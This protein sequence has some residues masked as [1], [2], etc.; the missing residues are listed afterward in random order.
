MVRRKYVA[1]FML[2]LLS[3]LVASTVL[4]RFLIVV[5]PET[6][7]LDE[8]LFP[9]L[10]PGNDT[11]GTLPSPSVPVKPRFTMIVAGAAHTHYL[12]R[13]VYTDYV[14]GTWV[15]RNATSIPQSAVAPPEVAIP[16]HAERDS[17]TITLFS[18]FRGNLY[19]SLYTVRVNAVGVEAVPDY[20]LFRTAF[21][22]TSYSFSSVAFTFDW[23]Y[24]LNVTAGNQSEYLV[25]PDDPELMNLSE[26]ITADAGS[27]YLKALAIMRYLSRHYKYSENTSAPQG[28]ERLKWFLFESGE[29]SSYDFA[30]AFVILARMS[31][32]PAR[33]V[34]GLYI[35]AV[36]QAQVVTERNIHYWAEVYFRETGWLT[37]D[38]LHPDPNIFVPFE[39]SV[40]PDRM[41]LGPGENG[42][43]TLKLMR[44]A[45]G[46]NATVTVKSPD[47]RILAA[48]DRAGVYS[49]E[50]GGFTE[51]GYY[52]VMINASAGG[53]PF[54]VVRFVPVTVPGNLTVFPEAEQVT[55]LRGG[56]SWL[57]VDVNGSESIPAVRSS[58]K[59]F[60]M[61]LSIG[62][63]RMSIGLLA[64]R[65]SE[66]GWRIEKFSFV[67]G[68]GAFDLYI[69]VLVAESSRV[70]LSSPQEGTAG[71]E[72]L[73]KG[74]VKAGETSLGKGN[75]LVYTVSGGRL[76]I[77]G[78][79]NVS[80]DGSFSISGRLPKS[81]PPGTYGIT[82]EYIPPTGSPYLP[83]R[84]TV[85]VPVKGLAELKV[86]DTVVSRPGRVLVGGELVGGDGRAIAN[87]TIEYFVDGTPSGTVKTTDDGRFSIELNV[88]GIERHTLRLVYGG[89]ANYSAAGGVVNV[90]TVRMD[91]PERVETE[92]GKPVEI[93]GRV[94]GLEG[95]TITAYV[96]PGK[97]YTVRVVNETFSLVLEPF[98]TVGERSVDFRHGANVL[99]RNTV[100]VMSPV[101]V[102]LLTPTA[103]GEETA[104]LVFRL[105]DGDGNPLQNVPVMVWLNGTAFTLETNGSGVAVLTVPV[106]ERSTNTTVT[107]VFR[108]TR[109]Y[110][111]VNETFHVVISPKRSVPW[112]YI[113]ALLVIA[114][115]LLRYRL[116]RKRAG[117]AGEERIL[118][119]IFNNGVPLFR[120]GE[121]VEL[122]VECDGVP[123][124]YVDGKSVGRGRD[125]RLVLSPG[126]HTVEARC[127]DL[128][129]AARVRVVGR[130]NDA[131]VEYYERCFL[132][133]ARNAGVEVDGMT[134]REIAAEL[135]GRMYPWEPVDTLTEIFE[136][137]KYSPLEISR[138]EFIRF[139]RAVLTLTGGE[140]VV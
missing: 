130:Y 6:P 133:W 62:G 119:I 32:L 30:S 76:V 18:P 111:P 7:S 54:R 81:L 75:V 41:T 65:D 53:Y 82:A 16:H 137:A 58:S 132:P 102:E 63:R 92:V 120:D 105:M 107:V 117:A 73:V 118:K 45:R 77:L 84:S 114:A 61:A 136:R 89:S 26:M 33:L 104:R 46:I 95:G 83:N 50:V 116:A 40:S 12:R 121:V 100:V 35:D 109:Y 49:V 21:N 28:Y 13:V 38:P 2:V 86:P 60:Y 34:E 96:F 90:F 22:L 103:S 9:T 123:E 8:L 85:N 31:G 69:P 39:L 122:T 23:P 135:T 47:G 37:F 44:V 113:G 57:D 36:P 64:G 80:G 125:F 112:L 70:V 48:F 4:S 115:V 129:E 14:N 124:L 97:S 5:P 43:L 78:Y 3:M 140:C 51:P 24:L 19:T 17:V 88:S 52:P 108:G 128:V 72:L 29:G 134:P 127:G 25:V 91:V 27:D 79:A 98:Q 106:P 11:D 99:G 10:S 66:L 20:N 93:R 101:R 1:F 59:L 67:S 110:L 71:K 87:A 74:Y 138:S 55:L 56:Q 42:T 131:V 68:N 15:T 94:I 126:E 139:Y